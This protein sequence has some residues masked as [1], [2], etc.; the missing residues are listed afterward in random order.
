MIGF[1]DLGLGGQRLDLADARLSGFA[2]GSRDEDRSVVFDIDLGTGLFGDRADHLAALP[3]DVADLVRMNLD[4]DDPRRI[5]RNILARF[6][7]RL[8][9]DAEDMQAAFTGLLQRFLQDHRV[10]A[11]DL[12]IHLQGGDAFA[13]SR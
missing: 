5:W 6:R 13:R 9:H 10:D 7:D 1:A 12:D 3:D 11:G 2:V 4:R 8:F